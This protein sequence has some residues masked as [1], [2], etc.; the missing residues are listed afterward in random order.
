MIAMNNPI[1]HELVVSKYI[2]IEHRQAKNMMISEL[3]RFK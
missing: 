3:N 2:A 1:K